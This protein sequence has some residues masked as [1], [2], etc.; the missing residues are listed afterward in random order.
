MQHLNSVIGAM[1]TSL[2]GLCCPLDKVTFTIKCYWEWLW[3][4]AL[5]PWLVQCGI[6]LLGCG[7]GVIGPTYPYLLCTPPKSMMRR[8]S[9]FGASMKFYIILHSTAFLCYVN[10]FIRSWVCLG[11]CNNYSFFQVYPLR[12]GWR[13]GHR[14]WR[15][16]WRQSLFMV[17]TWERRL[18]LFF[19]TIK[20]LMFELSSCMHYSQD[21][22][23]LG[24]LQGWSSLLCVQHLWWG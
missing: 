18:K 23:T 13:R 9:M 2:D 5:R 15:R 6:W 8:W 11:V 19:L 21:G 24:I 14:R 1:Q 20:C 17:F 10:S 22:G 3:R 16:V 4:E 7:W 12:N